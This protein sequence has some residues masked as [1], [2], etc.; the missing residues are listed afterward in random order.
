MEQVERV[1]RFN[2]VI[3]RQIGALETEFL[4]RKRPLGASRVLYELGDGTLEVRVLRERLG[5]DSGYASRLVSSLSSEGLVRVR[6]SGT[7]ARVRTL[8]LTAAG[9]KE[10]AILNQ[11]SD[12]R[13]SAVLDALDAGQREK[14][15]Q[16]MDTVERMLLAAS[17]VVAVEDPDSRAARQCLSRYCTELA[18]RF[19]AGFDPDRS[20]SA[21]PEELR[22]PGGCFVIARCH[23]RPVGCGA[24]K[25]HDD[26]AEIKRMWVDRN[27]RGGGVGRRILAFLETAAK[28]R[29][30]DT[31]RLETNE[32]LTEARALYRRCGYR[33]VPAFNDE[34]YAHHWF[35]KR[36]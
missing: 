16:A 12:E 30:I 28:D 8:E 17:I 31:V 19:E 34:P 20:I 26:F 10:L 14:L 18:E 13:A 5:L 35:E 21:S 36:L 27:Y 3:T 11:S 29:E 33:E 7:D 9:R 23:G 15:V 2:R 24:V 1:R 4:G 22:P 6:R 32:A 25:L